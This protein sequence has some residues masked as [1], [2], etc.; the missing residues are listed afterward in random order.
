LIAQF[1][2][3]HTDIEFGLLDVTH[4]DAVDCRLRDFGS[5]DRQLVDD[6]LLGH[7]RVHKPRDYVGW[8]VHGVILMH[9]CIE[10]NT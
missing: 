5:Q 8:F 2:E 7:S 9:V 3:S 6:C 10:C 4:L 1:Q